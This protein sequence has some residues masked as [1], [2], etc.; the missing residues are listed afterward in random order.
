MWKDS[1]ICYIGGGVVSAQENGYKTTAFFGKIVNEIASH[2]KK[3]ILVVPVVSTQ[4][5]HDWVLGSNI[6]VRAVPVGGT[7]IGN[8]KVTGKW[9]PIV[10]SAILSSD[11]VFIRGLFTPALGCIYKS[12]REQRKPLLHWIIGNP[13]AL[14][15][16]H[17]RS[18][19]LK[20]GLGII[21]THWWCAY[22]DY[23]HNSSRGM[24]GYICNGSEI[25]DAFSKLNSWTIVSSTL[26]ESDYF[27][28]NN[29]C[30]EK[31]I[32]IGTLCYLRPEKGIE[33]L[34][35]SFSSC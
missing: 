23:L 5:Q 15:R 8:V 12:C 32:R 21:Y 13:K 14:L 24:A 20:D 22:L 9:K 31:V 1:V 10:T 27:W 26:T 28:R 16:S 33:D 3:M 4:T 17:R 2:F 6:E 25:R 34:I 18:G 11:C 30:F 35:E 7:A 29:T 19:F